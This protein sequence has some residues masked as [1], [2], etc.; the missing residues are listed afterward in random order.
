ML[1]YVVGRLGQAVLVLWAAYT[2]SFI[3]LYLL[4]S[5]P[6]QIL[7][8]RSGTATTTSKAQIAQIA[9]EYGYDQPV[10]V[11][12]FSQL[13]KALRLDF[14]QSVSMHQPVSSLIAQNLPPTLALAGTAILFTAVGGIVLAFLATYVGWRPLRRLLERLPALGVSFPTFFIGLLL[15]Q[16]LSFDLHLFPSVGSA[17]PATLVLPALTMAIPTSGILAQVL[18]RGMNDQLG[19]GYITTARAKGLSKFAVHAVHAFR[20]AALPALTILGLI[21]GYTV[22]G[23][24]VAETVFSRLGIGR[25][26]QQAVLAQDI[27][28]VQGIVVIAAAGFV[29]VNVVVDLVYPLLDPR[30]VVTARVA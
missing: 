8:N 24:V 27:P 22:A 20:N 9:H 21:V 25:L 11:Q 10:I 19:E 29:L 3:V 7:I 16:L 26:A 23:A 5:D 2:V 15:I 13:G 12:Y 28:L 18:I 17:T 30:V 4:P 6:V 14:G 1:K